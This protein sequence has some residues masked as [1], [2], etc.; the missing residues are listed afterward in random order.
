MFYIS[1]SRSWTLRLGPTI[2][3]KLWP[4]F[5]KRA[6]ILLL[7]RKPAKVHAEHNRPQPLQG[8]NGQQA[9][10]CA[11]SPASLSVRGSHIWESQGC[12]ESQICDSII[13][14]TKGSTMSLLSIVLRP[15][16][17]GFGQSPHPTHL[18]G[19]LQGRAR[20][21][22]LCLWAPSLLPGGR[23]QG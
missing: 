17:T 12:P 1:C 9:L 15:L 3:G 14:I 11:C 8:H 23:G 19:T 18:W 16:T 6:T 5:M 21:G 20:S 7:S 4:T 10:S 13:G 2:G 22:M